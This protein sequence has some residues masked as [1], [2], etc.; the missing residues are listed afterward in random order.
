VWIHNES[1]FWWKA[2]FAFISDIAFQPA[3]GYDWLQV[4]R[5]LR[6]RYG[7]GL[8]VPALIGSKKL[9]D[10]SALLRLA[11]GRINDFYKNC[12]VLQTRF[13]MASGHR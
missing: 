10:L 4:M 1:L 6:S 3:A 9:S 2:A 7:S 13:G 11:R 8:N 5:A 12:E